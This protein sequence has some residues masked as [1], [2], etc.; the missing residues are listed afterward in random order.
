MLTLSS[1]RKCRQSGRTF[2]T[3]KVKSINSSGAT[4]RRKIVALKFRAAT[5]T[6]DNAY[7]PNFMEI[8]SHPD[9]RD[10]QLLM[11]LLW[12]TG[13][14]ALYQVRAQNCVISCI[15]QADCTWPCSRGATVPDLDIAQDASAKRRISSPVID[16]VVSR[17]E[18]RHLS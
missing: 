12:R 7:H 5:L 1:G 6:A 10:G 3:M 17:D 2:V 8:L 14:P 11:S 13:L 15:Y 16:T 9:L 4:K 18:S